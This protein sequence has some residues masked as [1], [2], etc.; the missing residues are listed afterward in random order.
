[1][2]CG[3]I[4][5]ALERS[6]AAEIRN[7][8]LSRGTRASP[9]SGD[10][11]VSDGRQFRSELLGQGTRPELRSA[12]RGFCG[13]GCLRSGLVLGLY[14]LTDGE[15]SSHFFCVGRWSALIGSLLPLSDRWLS[16]HWTVPLLFGCLFSRSANRTNT[17]TALAVVRRT[18]CV[19]C[20]VRV[21]RFGGGSRCI[22][23]SRLQRDSP[24]F[25]ITATIERTHGLPPMQ[26]ETNRKYRIR[27]LKF[28][29]HFVPTRAPSSAS[30]R[31]ELPSMRRARHHVRAM[32]STDE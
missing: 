13:H 14:G 3:R 15:H 5:A 11:R 25:F 32:T 29:A 9:R 23:F 19:A 28:A 31:V 16:R 20:R 2:G 21:Q 7:P 4:S 6:G 18:F 10:R 27:L 30:G 24:P 17:R 1:L 26:G 12:R 8:R 22:Q